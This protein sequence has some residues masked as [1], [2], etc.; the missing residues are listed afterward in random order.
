M[1]TVY[2][3]YV[4]DSIGSRGLPAWIESGEEVVIDGRTLVRVSEVVILDNRDKWHATEA[5]ARAE[6]LI[7]IYDAASL[8]ATQAERI[9]QEGQA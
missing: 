8:L 5:A 9:A 2:R 1:A 3:P 7:K 6:L 4:G